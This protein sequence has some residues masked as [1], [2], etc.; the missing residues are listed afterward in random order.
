MRDTKTTRTARFFRSL[1]MIGVNYQDA[2]KLRL[3]ERALHRWAEL[4]CGDSNDY[5]SWAI[6]RDDE[7]EKPYFVRHVY[8]RGIVG[9]QTYRTPTADREAGALK[10][11]SKIMANYPSLTFYHQ[12]DPRGCAL[13]LVKK[14][15]VSPNLDQWNNANLRLQHPV[16][17]RCEEC[18]NVAIQSR[19]DSVYTRGVACCID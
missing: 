17:C 13:W 6:E 8:A 15:D 2:D 5:S 4:E 19:L 11:L 16:G 14:S 1:E 18:Q 9:G 10:R 3:I 12:T 7:N